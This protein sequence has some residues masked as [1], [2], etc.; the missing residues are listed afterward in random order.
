MNKINTMSSANIRRRFLATVSATALLA[1]AYGASA[2]DDDSDRPILWIELGGQLEQLSDAQEEFTPPFLASITQ[3][4]LVSA[5]NVQKPPAYAI[6]ED[7]KISFQPGSSDW[8]FSAA[9]QYGRQTVNQQRHQQTKNAKVPVDFTFTYGTRNFHISH[10]YYPSRHV[11][12]ADGQS[13]QNES[14]AIVDFQAGKDVGLGMFGGGGTSVLSAGIRIAQFT[15]KSHVS[16]AAEP[17][18]HYPSGP[19]TSLPEWQAFKYQQP[20]IVFH[21]YAGNA[22]ISRSFRGFGPAAS[23]TASRRIMGDTSGG[24]L[25]IDWEAN[26]AV[27]FG[28]QKVRGHHQTTAKTYNVSHWRTNFN[29]GKGYDR[30][31]FFLHTTANPRGVVGVHNNAPPSLSRAHSVMVPNLGASAGLSLK[32]SNAKVSFGYRADFFFG[33]MDG[34]ID[35]QRKENQGFYG[36]FA[37]V[38]VGLGG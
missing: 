21:D 8:F 11:K 19:I 31:G 15:S 29:G 3:G 2:A 33:A 35:A 23:W 7:G 26:G 16:L 37:T 36:P 17:D 12:F 28:R 34:G 24:E 14:H 13:R 18:V 1:S 22:D 5:L 20:P 32:Y 6:A 30:V 4:N 9:I 38:S 27:L 10:S 25:D